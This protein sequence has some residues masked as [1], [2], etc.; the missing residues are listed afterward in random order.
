MKQ[1]VNDQARENG[2]QDETSEHSDDH[3][4]ASIATA[5]WGDGADAITSLP[6]FGSVIEDDEISREIAASLA[7]LI[8]LSMYNWR[9]AQTVY[10]R[11]AC[12]AQCLPVLQNEAALENRIVELYQRLYPPRTNTDEHDDAM[13]QQGRVPVFQ[14]RDMDVITHSIKFCTGLEESNCVAASVKYALSLQIGDEVDVL[15]RNGCWNDGVVV[16]VFR[17]S[18]RVTKYVLMRFSLWAA[19]SVEWVAVADGRILPRGIAH[20][21]WHACLAQRRLTCAKASS[22]DT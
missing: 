5:L 22:A 6:S 18:D 8:P 9:L 21:K 15:D 13:A 11:A 7:K 3:A 16:D 14:S 1:L 4:A 10:E 20:A 17:E 2:A 12:H 19:D